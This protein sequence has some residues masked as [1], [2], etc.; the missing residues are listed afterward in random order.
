M[1]KHIYLF[2]LLIT[3]LLVGC[4][5]KP[6]SNLDLAIFNRGRIKEIEKIAFD[7]RKFIDSC[8]F[9]RLETSDESLFG[10]ITQLETFDGKFYIFDRQTM[11][12]KVFGHTGNF[13][14]NIGKLGQGPGEYSAIG[15]FF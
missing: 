14:Y 3:L 5:E 13:L 15:F 9:V 6:R 12:L 8:E 1:R 2:L 11:K 7:N 4:R 10:E